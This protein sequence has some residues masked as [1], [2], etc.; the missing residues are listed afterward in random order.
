MKRAVEKV[1]KDCFWLKQGP[2]LSLLEVQLCSQLEIMGDESLNCIDHDDE[3]H[4]NLLFDL[5][6]IYQPMCTHIGNFN[7]IAFL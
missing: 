5:R 1:N 2:G 4:E 7:S 3:F 6:S